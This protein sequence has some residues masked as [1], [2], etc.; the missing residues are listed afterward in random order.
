MAAT[1]NPRSRFAFQSDV[2]IVAQQPRTFANAHDRRVVFLVKLQNSLFLR[3]SHV[4]GIRVGIEIV[5]T[6]LK[7]H[8]PQGIERAR[9]NDWHVLR[10]LDCWSRNVG[11]SAATYVRRSA[12]YF[13]ANS[14]DEVKILQSL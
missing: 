1:E 11:A 12:A 10:R 9:L 3:F 13:P 6:D 2:T 4:G 14:F 7:R 5:R 8:K